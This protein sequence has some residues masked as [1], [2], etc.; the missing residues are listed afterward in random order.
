MHKHE[1]IPKLERTA[2]FEEFKRDDFNALVEYLSVQ[3]IDEGA[4]VFREGDRGG[5]LCLLLEGRLAVLKDAGHGEKK[6]VTEV[7]A[8]KLIGEISL[9][10]GMPHS[11]TVIAAAPSTLVLLSRENLARICD[12]RPRIGNR[13]LWKIGHLL[14]LRLRQ[15]TGKLVDHL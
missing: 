1:L 6:K 13:L 14:S 10:D 15:T 7:T 11:A 8:G 5:H 4:V 12:E 3:K 2:I 9:M